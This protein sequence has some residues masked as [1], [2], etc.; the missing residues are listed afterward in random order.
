MVFK[1]TLILP[2]GYDAKRAGQEL[3]DKSCDLTAVG[4]PFRTNPDLV[5]RWNTG[6]VLN[7]IGFSTFYMPGPKGFT[8]Y[9]RHWPA[10]CLG[11]E[12]ITRS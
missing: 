10:I 9:R 1:R 11:F 2:A 7:D 5:G 8:N 12:H 6:A 3:E 4:R